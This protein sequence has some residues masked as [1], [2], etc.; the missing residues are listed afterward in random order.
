MSA[1]SRPLKRYQTV[2]RRDGPGDHVIKP[3][4]N[5]ANPRLSPLLRALLTIFATILT[6]EIST[7]YT[8]HLHC[9]ALGIL[10]F[11]VLIRSFPASVL[12]GRSKPHQTT[13]PS[14]TSIDPLDKAFVAIARR[15]RRHLNKHVLVMASG[16]R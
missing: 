15:G 2:L 9:I 1:R 14:D 16:R 3:R 13:L 6:Y 7:P 10:V 11:G 12:P 5:I 4:Q 8:L